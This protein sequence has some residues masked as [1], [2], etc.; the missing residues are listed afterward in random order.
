M[1]G[2]IRA[3]GARLLQGT[4]ELLFP[5]GVLCLC[6]GTALGGE[7]TDGVCPACREALE[8][9]SQRQEE[10]E[11]SLSGETL[12]EGIDF[13]HAAFPYEDQART[14][15]CR[16]K[17]ESV[18][19]AAVPLA[20]A[21]ALLPA[22]E[23]ELIV[24]VPT[25]SRRR[26]R[27]GF[28]Q[29]ALLAGHVAETLGM[30]M[31]EALVRTSHRAPQTGLNAGQRRANLAGCM[32]AGEAVRGRRV[33]LVDDVYTT[34]A[35]CCEAARALRAA[36]AVSVGV[37]AAARSVPGAQKLPFDGPASGDAHR[38]RDKNRMKL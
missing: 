28:D 13:V 6:C 5:R 14:L 10:R 36:G 38:E 18:R 25:D 37:F 4:E 7:E 11:R 12:P 15:I 22:G 17:F 31:R 30:P 32:R 29:S 21:M 8:R 3:W 33:L 34:G 20:G 24:P 1:Q 16:L 2:R 23:E 26:R 9:L 27:R 19:S 35:T